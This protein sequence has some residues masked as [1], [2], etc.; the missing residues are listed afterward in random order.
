MYIARHIKCKQSV[1][2]NPVDNN[3]IPNN[4]KIIDMIIYLVFAFMFKNERLWMFHKI[5]PI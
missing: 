4:N 3:H 1:F 5:S 2:N